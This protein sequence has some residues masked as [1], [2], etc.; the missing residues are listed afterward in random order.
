MM[1]KLF[2]AALSLLLAA[3][4]AAP[5]SAPATCADPCPIIARSEGYVLPAAT[6]AS[7]ARI[8]FSSADIGHVTSEGTGIGGEPGCFGIRTTPGTDAPLVTLRIEGASVVAS[9]TDSGGRDHEAPCASAQA[10]PAGG[11]VVPFY[12]TIHSNMRG[13]VVVS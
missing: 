7:G 11:F 9:Y 2:L 13:S 12:C 6:I 5:A 3:P 8:A 4:L 1:T 10:L